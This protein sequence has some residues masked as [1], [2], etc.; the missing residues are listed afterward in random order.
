MENFTKCNH[1]VLHISQSFCRSYRILGPRVLFEF[2]FKERNLE[3]GRYLGGKKY[4]I[5]EI[6]L[7]TSGALKFSDLIESKSQGSQSV[8]RSD[9]TQSHYLKMG[10]RAS[11]RAR[12]QFES[13][14]VLCEIPRQ[15]RR[16]SPDGFFSVDH[17]GNE[18]RSF[19]KIVTADRRILV[20]LRWDRE[21]RTGDRQM[22]FYACI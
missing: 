8:E 20:H 18:S 21:R 4:D 6:K 7:R 10:R 11:E 13:A 9:L 17:F 15:S 14:A 19:I 5:F 1:Y 22:V 16:L 12:N 3:R 2:D